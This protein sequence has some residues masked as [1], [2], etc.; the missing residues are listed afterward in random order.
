MNNKNDSTNNSNNNTNFS[1]PKPK[2]GLAEKHDQKGHDL[3]N[4][5]AKNQDRSLKNSDTSK[6]P[7]S[8]D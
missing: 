1:I 5:E 7:E 3:K 6:T 4:Q 2:E 8:D